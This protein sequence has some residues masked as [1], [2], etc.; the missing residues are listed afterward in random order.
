LFSDP[1]SAKKKK[2]LDEVLGRPYRQGKEYLYPSRC[3]GHHKPKLSINFEKNAAKCWA[4][5]W[6]TKN[7]RRIVRRWGDISHINRWK[8][9]D[10]DIE[11][12]DLDNLFAK[13]IEIPQRIDLPNEFKTL[14]GRSHPPSSRM[15]FNYLRK[16]GVTDKDILYWKIGYCGSG[17]YKNRVILPSFDEDGYCNFFTSRTYDPNVWPPYLNGPGNKDIIFNELLVDWE[18]E[19]TL[20][21][22]VFDA[23]VA[24]ENSIPLLGSTLREDSKLFRKI[25]KNDTPVLLGLDADA[26][27]K[28]MR[29]VKALLAYDIEVRLM[30]TSGYKDIGE[31]PVE[32]FKERKENAPFIDS[33]A[34]LIRI[35]LSA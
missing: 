31:M 9:F 13:E 25:V 29:L 19:V 28:A 3:C 16:R 10:A 27:K 1:A 22:G 14:T 18:R 7:L 15:V 34:Y 21:E 24:G 33:D 11:L 8:D 5:D 23:I 30:D 17:D 6:R 35:A 4:C 32:V 12:G 20:V 26:Q 2:I